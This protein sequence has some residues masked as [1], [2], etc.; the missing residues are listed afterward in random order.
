M[1]RLNA[2][3]FH[4][5]SRSCLWRMLG[6]CPLYVHGAYPIVFGGNP[7]FVLDG[8]DTWIPTDCVQDA[9]PLTRGGQRLCFGASTLDPG[10]GFSYAFAG[11]T[12][13]L[14]VSEQEYVQQ[15]FDL[16]V[17]GNPVLRHQ[18]QFLAKRPG[19][20]KRESAKRLKLL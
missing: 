6:T 11:K 19:P 5:I 7:V 4:S 20:N 9:I 17:Q 1:P 2:L 15:M 18:Q 14:D 8:L 12:R 13:E 10:Y 3:V 16:F